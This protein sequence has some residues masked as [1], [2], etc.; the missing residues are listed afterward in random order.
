MFSKPD[1]LS[2]S[3]QAIKVYKW[4]PKTTALVIFSPPLQYMICDSSQ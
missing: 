1:F 2:G 3:P 4:V